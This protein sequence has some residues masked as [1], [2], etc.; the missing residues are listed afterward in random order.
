MKK[1]FFVAFVMFFSFAGVAFAQD[2]YVNGYYRS[3]GTY[4]QPHYRSQA[5][6]NPYNNYSTQGNVNPYTGNQGTRDPY[7]NGV[8]SYRN[9]YRSGSSYS[10][11]NSSSS[12]GYSTGSPGGYFNNGGMPVLGNQGGQRSRSNSPFN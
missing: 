8:G 5:D 7:N 9:S 3:D 4:V 11:E 10:N 2:G 6:G 12:R 1:I